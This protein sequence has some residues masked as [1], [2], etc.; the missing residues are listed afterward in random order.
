MGFITSIFLVLMQFKKDS[1][2]VEV[3]EWEQGE[4]GGET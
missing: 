2:H 4:W 3:W 1:K